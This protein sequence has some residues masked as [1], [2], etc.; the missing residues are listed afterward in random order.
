MFDVILVEYQVNINIDL[1]KF[2]LNSSRFTAPE[3]QSDIISSLTSLS[4]S[5]LCPTAMIDSVLT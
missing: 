1:M 5:R 3:H 2:Q 4:L